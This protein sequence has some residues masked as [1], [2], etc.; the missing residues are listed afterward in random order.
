MSKAKKQGKSGGKESSGEKASLF[1]GGP[2]PRLPPPA[3][4]TRKPRAINKRAPN[5][6]V[7]SSAGDNRTGRLAR[8]ATRVDETFHSFRAETWQLWKVP[9]AERANALQF[10]LGREVMDKEQDNLNRVLPLHLLAA[11]LDTRGR[12]W[13]E[14]EE[15]ERT[16]AANCIQSD[17]TIDRQ[18]DAF[19]NN[20]LLRPPALVVPLRTVNGDF[21]KLTDLAK[22]PLPESLWARGNA[23]LLSE[24]ALTF[25]VAVNFTKSFPAAVDAIAVALT[26][27]AERLGIPIVS[28]SRGV[29]KR[30]PF[31]GLLKLGL[32]RFRRANNKMKLAEAVRHWNEFAAE[33]WRL[34]TEWGNGYEQMRNAGYDVRTLLK[35]LFSEKPPPQ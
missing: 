17:R 34:E 11:L 23:Q 14:L 2:S 27:Y 22:P 16:A 15:E 7:T 3:P 8:L 5:K 35:E 10:E 6:S 26:A 21:R 31:S 4:L 12:A 29:K 28:Q 18:L 30:E 1:S 24:S 13:L 20:D 19:A 33:G 32:A 25:Q 9:K